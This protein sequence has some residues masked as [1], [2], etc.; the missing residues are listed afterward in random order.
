MKFEPKKP[1]ALGAQTDIITF[2]SDYSGLSR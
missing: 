2:I 1:P